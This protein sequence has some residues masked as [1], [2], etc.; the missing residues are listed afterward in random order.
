MKAG[1]VFL[2]DY[3]ELIKSGKVEPP[4]EAREGPYALGAVIMVNRDSLDKDFRHR[5]LPQWFPA[6]VCLPPPFAGQWYRWYDPFIW[7][8]TETP[9]HPDSPAMPSNMAYV[10]KLWSPDWK[11][12][13]RDQWAYPVAEWQRLFRPLR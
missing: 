9:I 1:D 13:S 3:T 12:D 11:P 10:G 8:E 7:Y 4:L 2:G 6:R 5:G